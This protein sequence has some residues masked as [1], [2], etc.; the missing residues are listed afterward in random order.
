MVEMLVICALDAG[1]QAR[2]PSGDPETVCCD[3]KT[4]EPQSNDVLRA[5]CIRNA[6]A[7]C[8][9]LWNG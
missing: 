6:L 3:G 1:E 5:R 9:A 2:R 7:N 4:P 8:I